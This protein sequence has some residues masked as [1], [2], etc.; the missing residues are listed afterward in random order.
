M[1]K[2][3]QS[4][5][6]HIG[7]FGRRNTGKSSLINSLAGY[8]LSLVSPVAGTTTDPVLK[9]I[10]IAPLGPV[11]LLDTAG[12]DDEG[13]LGELRIKMT[14]ARIPSVHLAL[15][16]SDGI[17]GEYEDS[18]LKKLAENKIPSL[19]VWSKSDE[20]SPG[21][22]EKEQ[23]EKLG[24]ESISVSVT[25]GRGL[26]SLVMAMIKALPEEAF[27]SPPILRDLIP[28]QGL[29]LFVTPIDQGAP[30]GRLIVPQV[31]SLRDCLDAH[32]LSFLVQTEEIPRALALLKNSPDLLVCDSQAVH[33]CV[34]AVDEKI[35]LTTFSILM[36][37]L[38]FDLAELSAGA[39]MIHFLKD[40]DKVCISEVCA[41]HSQPEDIG[42]VKIPRLLKKFTG[43][44]LEIEF[45]AGRDFPAN[46]GAFKLLI[47][48]GGCM[49]NRP[50]M[51]YRMAEA[52][53]AGVAITN[54]GVAM[55]LMQ[56]VLERSLQIFP[57]ALAAYN[58]A[59]GKYKN[60]KHL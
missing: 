30:K 26:R 50:T 9:S 18:L 11:V 55:S 40:G 47:H 51:L 10:E 20:S 31:Q 14:M 28:E 36:A 34:E 5:R 38:K 15:I 17:W 23:V 16:V 37:R 32:A 54:Y 4:L 19:V 49:S 2:E 60:C 8:E 53:R 44:K 42:R 24:L 59:K 27:E 52:K 46:L 21:F 1:F 12:I 56:K 29:C 43:K 7:L 57:V 25:K 35:P 6:P 33:K 58:D 45:S 39:A 41:H 13:E 48:C 22:K 3:A